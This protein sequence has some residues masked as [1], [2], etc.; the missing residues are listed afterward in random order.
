MWGSKKIRTWSALQANTALSS[1]NAELYALLKGAMHAN[2]L[3]SLALDF[4]INLKAVIRS[5]SSAAMGITS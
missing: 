5:D 2:D 1:G 4:D 3:V